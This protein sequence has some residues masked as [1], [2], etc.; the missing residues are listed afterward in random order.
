MYQP[1]DVPRSFKNEA[2]HRLIHYRWAT[3]STYPF[4]AVFSPMNSKISTHRS[5]SYSTEITL[6]N[7][8]LNMQIVNKK[9][10]GDSLCKIFH[11][12]CFKTS[13]F[14]RF[15]YGVSLRYVFKISCQIPKYSDYAINI[16]IN[17]ILV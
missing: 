6:Q 16:A 11:P 2:H 1:Y 8:L 13:N 10:V 17:N 7:T 4:F 5:N 12:K 3:S 9:G 14:D 15:R